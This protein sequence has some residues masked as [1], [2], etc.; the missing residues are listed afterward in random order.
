MCSHNHANICLDLFFLEK[1]HTSCA[2]FFLKKISEIFSQISVILGVP[3]LCLTPKLKTLATSYHL[4][5]ALKLLLKASKAVI[6]IIH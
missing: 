4:R 3:E 5:G 1:K 6:M 2:S